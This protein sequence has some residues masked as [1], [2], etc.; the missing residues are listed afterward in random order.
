VGLK[1][2][3]K[4]KPRKVVSAVLALRNWPIALHDSVSSHDLIT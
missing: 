2:K 3:P 4:P 1:P